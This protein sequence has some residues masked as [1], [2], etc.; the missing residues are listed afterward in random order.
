M[1]PLLCFIA[2]LLLPTATSSAATV[3]SIGTDNN[4]NSE[5]EQEGGGRNDSKYYWENGN[6]STLTGVTSG[7]PA[8]WAGGMEPWSDT[9]AT[10]YG[11]ARAIT[12]S[13]T[14]HD[15]FFK[16]DAEDV[17]AGK[18]LVFNIDFI[19][20]GFGAPATESRHDVEFL[21]NGTVFHSITGLSTAQLV[22]ATIDASALAA[23][24]AV[25]SWRRT[26]G[27]TGGNWISIDYVTLSSVPE[28]T[29]GLLLLVGSML[30]VMR[31]A[32]RRPGTI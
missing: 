4:A 31:R 9:S 7:T 20:P 32:R 24:E 12:S 2:A 27:A 19:S 13:I 21:L 5:F 3:F 11:F 29:R 28:P 8:N 15:I 30:V 23:G 14:T 6:Y 25:L 18:S 22:T 17:G 16:L 26:G 1:K 10:G